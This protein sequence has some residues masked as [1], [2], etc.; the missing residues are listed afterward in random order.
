MATVMVSHQSSH[1]E[2]LWNALLDADLNV[3]YWTCISDRYTKWDQCLKL[4]VALSASGTVAARGYLVTISS[5]L[6]ASLGS[7]LRCLNNSSS[8]FLF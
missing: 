5:S 8:F 7:C 4:I 6:E 1:R 2:A 3:C